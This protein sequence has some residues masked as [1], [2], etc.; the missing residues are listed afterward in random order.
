MI[1]LFSPFQN[2]FKKTPALYCGLENNKLFPFSKSSLSYLTLIKLANPPG[3]QFLQLWNEDNESTY[4]TGLSRILSESICVK[5]LYH[6]SIQ[7]HL[8][9][10]RSVLGMQWVYRKTWLRWYPPAANLGRWLLSR[11]LEFIFFVCQ[12]W[13]ICHLIYGS[14]RIIRK[15]KILNDRGRNILNGD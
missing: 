3:S 9:L 2:K 12:V 6:S 1:I 13:E 7:W 8:V 5:R 11:K 14:L 4:L 10:G 15:V